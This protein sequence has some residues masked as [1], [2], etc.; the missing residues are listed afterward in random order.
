M[1]R[2]I[3]PPRRKEFAV[4]E[5]A[6]GRATRR[7]LLTR[8]AAGLGAVGVGLIAAEGTSS[9]D[10]MPDPYVRRDRMPINVKDYG[11]QGNGV[12][13]DTAAIQAAFNAS[14]ATVGQ[15]VFFPA[16][17]YLTMGTLNARLGLRI[18]GSGP[19]SVIRYTG[20]DYALLF[21][22]G[23]L[24]VDDPWTGMSIADLR[25]TAGGTAMGSG[26]KVRG[27]TRWSITNVQVDGFTKGYGI[28]LGG[29][30]FIGRIEGGRIR[31]CSI[32]ISAKKEGEEQACNAIEICGQL[33]IQDCADGIQL[34]DPGGTESAP[35]VG[36][37]V[38]IHGICV[39]GCTRGI[40]NVSANSVSV[41]DV[42]FEANTECDYR[43]G[44]T[45]NA[46]VPVRC[47]F[48]DND[49]YAP[50]PNST[51]IDLVRGLQPT[52]DGNYVWDDHE[53]APPPAPPPPPKRP[54][55]TIA[56][57]VTQATLG[58][59]N[60]IRLR[61]AYSDNGVQTMYWENDAGVPRLQGPLLGL[62]GDIAV[63][64]S[65]YGQVIVGRAGPGNEAGINLGPAH[66]AAVYR[67]QAD[68]V[69]VKSAI[70]LPAIAGA[71]VPNN[72]LFRDSA[73]NRLKWKDNAGMVNALY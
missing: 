72:T 64:G 57:G 9:A 20:A 66:D 12:T 6:P 11:A 41:H 4:I 2:T 53:P 67:T 69:H 50:L 3:R 18:V 26:I 44:S 25:V 33:E 29:S 19:S 35:I 15:T 68:V 1:R 10:P 55:F 24:A 59:S 56:D 61:P 73:D 42:Y 36:H 65:D 34:G 49:V 23:T 51:P 37:G 32:G 62:Q 8:G 5:E 63:R 40:W 31:T 52:L 70:D 22:L 48:N 38:E 21:G 16:G 13:D 54:A 45:H 43:L 7:R 28:L 71:S 27:A 47:S 60:R 17:T 58:W 30:S 39:E 14:L 46:S